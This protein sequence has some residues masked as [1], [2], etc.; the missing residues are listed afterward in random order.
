MIKFNVLLL[1]PRQ[2]LYKLYCDRCFAQH[3]SSDH[4]SAVT[5]TLDRNIRQPSN[6]KMKNGALTQSNME[7]F[8]MLNRIYK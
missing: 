6:S 7:N 4:V 1:P 3:P 2:V 5:L 8:R